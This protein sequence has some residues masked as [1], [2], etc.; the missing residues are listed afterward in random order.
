[1]TCARSRDSGRMLLSFKKLP[2]IILAKVLKW[3]AFFAIGKTR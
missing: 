3:G 1:M 2:Y